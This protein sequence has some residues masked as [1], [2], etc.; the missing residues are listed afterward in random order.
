MK[1]LAADVVFGIPRPHKVRSFFLE[2]A[3]VIKIS[4]ESLD[5]E[6]IT[7]CCYAL[8]KGFP[9]LIFPEGKI[10]TT[11]D[12]AVL[13]NGTSMVASRSGVPILPM[14]ISYRKKWY[15]RTKIYLGE[16][17]LPSKD[18]TMR[19]IEDTTKRMRVAME[20]LKERA[21]KDI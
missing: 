12:M 9:V 4:R 16:E 17:I 13:K 6:A 10:E 8:R 15:Q 18:K 1:I 5:L 7:D 2:Q 11:N 19:G 3:G 20:Q 21:E 14:F